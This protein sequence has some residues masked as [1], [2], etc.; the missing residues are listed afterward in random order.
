VGRVGWEH[1]LCWWAKAEVAEKHAQIHCGKYWLEGRQ[2]W[3]GKGRTVV[4]DFAADKD[5]R[6]GD[7]E[8]A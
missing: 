5:E 3:E 1:N 8:H 7:V 2:G 4:D 6:E